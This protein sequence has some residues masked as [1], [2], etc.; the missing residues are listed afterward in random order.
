M[1]A[2]QRPGTAGISSGIA[3]S[4]RWRGE[5]AAGGESTPCRSHRARAVNRE[6]DGRHGA[7]ANPAKHTFRPRSSTHSGSSSSS[8]TTATESFPPPAKPAR[9]SPIGSRGVIGSPGLDSTLLLYVM[10][11]LI[12]RDTILA[13]VAF[14][15]R[16]FIPELNHDHSL[17]GPLDGLL[18]RR[19][20][21]IDVDT[22]S[23]GVEDSEIRKRNG[24]E[25]ATATNAEYQNLTVLV[26]CVVNRYRCAFRIP[27]QIKPFVSGSWSAAGATYWNI[28][29][30]LRAASIHEH[31]RRRCG[32]A[33]VNAIQ[34][35][36]LRRFG[37]LYKVA[38]AKI[39]LCDLE[40]SRCNQRHR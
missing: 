9:A 32:H 12:K 18:T 13:L 39:L 28:R 19:L 2:G 38:L 10:P 24:L 1:A 22:D 35:D 37:V 40:L 33:A 30:N 36:V 17:L 11:I 23:L 20:N 26:Q 21:Q 16:R 4:C 31:H 8:T 7:A 14:A 3:A 6:C 27:D 15:I 34:A 25:S 29:E 5:T